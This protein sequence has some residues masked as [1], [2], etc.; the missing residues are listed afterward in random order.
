MYLKHSGHGIIVLI[1]V[2]LFQG[3]IVLFS[4]PAVLSL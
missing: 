1:S 4:E 2:E 3:W